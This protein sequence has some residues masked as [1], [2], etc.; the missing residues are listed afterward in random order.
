MQIYD[1]V[2]VT[3]DFSHHALD[4][5]WCTMEW[6][7]ISDDSE[8]SA[9][10]VMM[11]PL[12]ALHDCKAFTLDIAVVGFSRIEGFAGKSDWLFVLDQCRS[13]LLRLLEDGLVI[14]VPL[15]DAILLQQITK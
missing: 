15:P 7:V 13:K 8:T 10:E 12:D 2:V 1:G 5:G 9:I 11:E 3:L 4:P 6:F 14:G